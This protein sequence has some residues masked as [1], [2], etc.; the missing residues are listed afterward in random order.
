[1]LK[2]TIIDVLGKQLNT[3]SHTIQTG[4]NNI[5]LFENTIPSSGIYFV[6]MNIGAQQITRKIVIE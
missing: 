5:H 6:K 4:E 3:Y 1:Q 2:I